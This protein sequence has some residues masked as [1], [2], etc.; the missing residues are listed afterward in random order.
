MTLDEGPGQDKPLGCTGIGSIDFSSGES[1]VKRGVTV[2]KYNNLHM[3]TKV[4]KLEHI[5]GHS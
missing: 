5:S 4:Q 1:V 3:H 2:N